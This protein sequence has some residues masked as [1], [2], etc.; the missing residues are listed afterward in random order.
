MKFWGN[1]FCYVELPFLDW[2][3][4]E[5][6]R[7]STKYELI[8]DG[9]QFDSNDGLRL[10]PSQQVQAT[11]RMRF[12]TTD[13]GN[14]AS[15][16]HSPPS[17]SALGVALAAE[18][19]AKDPK[20]VWCDCILS[21]VLVPFIIRP[22]A[23]NF[24]AA[25]T[26]EFASLQTRFSCFTT[27]QLTL[28]TDPLAPPTFVALSTEEEGA[29]D[30]KIA[31]V[32]P[33]EEGEGGPVMLCVTV[34][35]QSQASMPAFGCGYLGS[36]LHLAAVKRALSLSVR[37]ATITTGTALLT[38]EISN[39]HSGNV[40][41][42]DAAVDLRSTTFGDESTQGQTV[43]TPRNRTAAPQHQADAHSLLLSSV[44]VVPLYSPARFPIAILPN[45]VYCIV[46]VAKIKQHMAHIVGAGPITAEMG[47][48][49]PEASEKRAAAIG[50]KRSSSAFELEDLT[51]EEAVL[52]LTSEV[53]NTN[54]VVDFETDTSAT[55]LQGV[56][57]VPWRLSV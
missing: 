37:S 5:A 39:V 24:E 43:P 47:Q 40:Y 1:F 31:F 52:R 4:I 56:A 48:L 29:I 42:T 28:G 7:Q 26:T 57:K 49:L 35:I 17:P 44:D 22:P 23:A 2:A 15:S 30:G 32:V 45:E 19:L 55:K 20:K 8:C 6:L 51:V 27:E 3:M 25:A 21:V 10:I 54:I 46:F 16:P 18:G 34:F 33:E 53:A 14:A 50:R 9:A 36:F 38:V 13:S 41:L 12:N 11:F